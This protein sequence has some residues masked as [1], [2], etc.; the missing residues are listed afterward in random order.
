MKRY[1][2]FIVALA[3]G[4]GLSACAEKEM[5]YD[6]THDDLTVSF[7]GAP[8]GVVSDAG[9]GNWSIITGP[10]Y[11]DTFTADVVTSSPWSVSV[12][13]VTVD[14]EEWVSVTESSSSFTIAL[15]D[16][17]TRDSRIAAVHVITEGNIPVAKTITVVQE[18]TDEVLVVDVAEE[19]P[20]GVTA[21]EDLDGTVE[22]VLPGDF[23]GELDILSVFSNIDYDCTFSYE[24][25]E[26]VSEWISVRED[27]QD[28]NALALAVTDNTDNLERT[29]LL[30]VSAV[31]GT[32]TVTYSFRF[33]QHSV[34]ALDW[35]GDFLQVN[36][37]ILSSDVQENVLVGTYDNADE[38]VF[39]AVPE[40][41]ELTAE[42][43]GIYAKV[44]GNA[45]TNL[46]RTAM[47]TMTDPA[48][49]TVSSQITFRQ[50]M[51]GYGVI[52]NKS[53]WELVSWGS[54][55]S[56]NN[57]GN[58]DSYFKLFN[59]HWPAD[60]AESEA[61]YNGS[62]NTFI[63]VGVG[64][65]ATPVI[66]VFDLGENPRKY[67]SF[68]LMPR[69]QWTGNSPKNARIEVS[70]DADG[71][72]TEVYEGAAFTEDLITVD[73]SKEDCYG[74]IVSWLGLGGS[75]TERYI[76][77]SLWGSF[78]GSTCLDEVFVSD[79]SGEESEE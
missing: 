2:S 23:S 17:G 6:W 40:W 27:G 30:E 65:E 67:D 56:Q 15:A 51:D 49:E 57:Q 73:G 77:L 32:L 72:W 16:N 69:L 19:L 43:G 79:R 47:V 76:R 20:E 29:A 58:I 53:L 8:A 62:K 12:D 24:G 66:F 25:S 18:N 34:V 46:E 55:N 22:V 59:N 5:E 31:S 10:S 1:V 37:I 64:A 38:V 7:A 50:C 4:F 14:D 75:R 54:D 3:A 11:T 63:E 28:G 33:V 26:D 39:S 42:E 68:G 36:E 13:Y 61:S 41:L 70:D 78:G 60:K 71:S 9:D 21:A 44:S 74:G 52:L 35:G 45:S 48:T